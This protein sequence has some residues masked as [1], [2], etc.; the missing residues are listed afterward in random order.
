MYRHA[1]IQCL[2]HTHA[3]HPPSCVNRW[4]HTMGPESSRD[5]HSPGCRYGDRR[6]A[7][8]PATYFDVGKLGH[9]HSLLAGGRPPVVTKRQV[10]VAATRHSL[11]DVRLTARDQ[12]REDAYRP[13]KFRSL[14]RQSQ[15][16]HFYKTSERWQ[17]A[18]RVWQDCPQTSLCGITVSADDNCSPCVPIV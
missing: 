1:R 6:P 2:A 14:V 8:S 12:L 3:S 13:S 4:H 18:G 9:Y 15:H 5:P 7:D 16:F 10:T 11:Q 17:M